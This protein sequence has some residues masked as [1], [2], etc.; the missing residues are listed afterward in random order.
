[1]ESSQ[2]TLNSSEPSSEAPAEKIQ[3]PNESIEFPR[4][5]LKLVSQAAMDMSIN[6]YVPFKDIDWPKV[7]VEN[8]DHVCRIVNTLWPHKMSLHKAIGLIG[9]FDAFKFSNEFCSKFVF[10]SIKK[11]IAIM[12]CDTS[13]FKNWSCVDA[14]KIDAYLCFDSVIDYVAHGLEEIKRIRFGSSLINRP[15]S[16]KFTM[17]VLFAMNKSETDRNPRN[18]FL[19]AQRLIMENPNLETQRPDIVTVG[20][21]NSEIIR[22]ADERIIESVWFPLYSAPQN[23][24]PDTIREYFAKGNLAMDPTKLKSY[25][26]RSEKFAFRA[27]G[28]T[29]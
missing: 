23:S 4:P 19:F 1:M 6:F 22:M 24:R 15:D 11:T 26:V 8:A 17:N 3:I 28:G 12:S 16:I 10:S 9:M 7:C 14:P 29:D 20:Q 13:K 25:D 5:N 27:C 21:L 18:F 2:T